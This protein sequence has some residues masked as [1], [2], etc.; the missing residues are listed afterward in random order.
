MAPL[1]PGFH[2]D[3]ANTLIF[4]R[5]YDDAIVQLQKVLEAEPNNPVLHR[6]LW[7]AFH[8][9]AMYEEALAEAKNHYT[10]LGDGR[11][12]AALERGHTEG[13]YREAM[14]RAA[15]TLAGRSKQT[16]VNPVLIAHVYALSGEKDRALDW[17][18]KAYQEGASLLVYLRVEPLYDPLRDDPRF[19]DLLRRMNFPE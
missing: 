5:R 2:I 11:V 14:R 17:L 7:Y 18:E 13:G 12:V 8:V 15:V 4:L 9:K 16:Y 1:N 6:A 10:A 19:Q 3:L